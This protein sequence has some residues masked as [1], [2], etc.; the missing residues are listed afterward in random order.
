M[1]PRNHTGV[2]TVVAL[3]LCVTAVQAAKND[4]TEGTSARS[5]GA[6]RDYYNRAGRLAFEK[7]DI[8]FCHVD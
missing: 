2:A 3:L 4:W 7:T 1:T 5:D 8:R 6:T